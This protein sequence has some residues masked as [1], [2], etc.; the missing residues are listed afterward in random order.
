[1]TLAN[2]PGLANL[3]ASLVQMRR[4]S[5]LTGD[6]SPELSMMVACVQ[7]LFFPNLLLGLTVTASKAVRQRS[8]AGLQARPAA[9]DE[10]H[11][12]DQDRR[13]G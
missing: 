10:S 11:V 5:E 7:L 12:L 4:E 3:R 2:E 1:M 9:T 13:A 6:V 8:R